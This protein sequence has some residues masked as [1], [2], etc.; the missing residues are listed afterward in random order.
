MVEEMLRFF[1][2]VQM[3]ASK[4]IYDEG[5]DDEVYNDEW[6]ASMDQDACEVNKM[7][8]DF[9][10]AMVSVLNVVLPSGWF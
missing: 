6:A 1:F 9:L 7:E 3:M 2:S 5:T 10:E 4:Y 8:M